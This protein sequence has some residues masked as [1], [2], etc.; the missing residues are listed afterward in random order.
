M[1]IE[2]GSQAAVLLYGNMFPIL[3]TARGCTYKEP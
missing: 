1:G 3:A 2:Y